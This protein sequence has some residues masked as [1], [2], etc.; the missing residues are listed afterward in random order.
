LKFPGHLSFFCTKVA[1][2]HLQATGADDAEMLTRSENIVNAN[3]Q[4]FKVNFVMV[5]DNLAQKYVGR[6]FLLTLV[7]SSAV[8]DPGSVFNFN[9]QTCYFF[10]VETIIKCS[11]SRNTTAKFG[12]LILLL[13]NSYLKQHTLVSQLLILSWSKMKANVSAFPC[14]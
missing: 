10:S 14:L 2:N 11:E 5:S 3:K 1:K 13:V 12:F 8:L 6:K 9:L 7:F 4:S